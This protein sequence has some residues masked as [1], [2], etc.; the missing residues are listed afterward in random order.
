MVM[1]SSLYYSC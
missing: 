1:V